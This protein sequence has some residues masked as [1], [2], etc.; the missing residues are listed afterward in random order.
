MYR[1]TGY[2]T[3][4]LSWGRRGILEPQ[5]YDELSIYELL[6]HELLTHELLTHELLTHELLTHELLTH[7]KP[8][9]QSQKSTL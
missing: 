9:K 6:T 1:N 7:E 2:P 4:A 3:S 5:A 8:S